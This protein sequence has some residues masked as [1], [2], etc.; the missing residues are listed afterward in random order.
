M[1][2]FSKDV[3]TELSRENLVADFIV[4]DDFED[5]SELILSLKISSEGKDLAINLSMGVIGRFLLSEELQQRISENQLKEETVVSNALSILYGAIRD[6]VNS[7]SAKMPTGTI[8][9][10][11]CV[12]NVQKHKEEPEAQEPTKVTIKKKKKIAKT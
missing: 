2:A 4:H 11:T 12:F 3:S 7:L 5:K 1:E 9:L 6:Q 10:P 8:F